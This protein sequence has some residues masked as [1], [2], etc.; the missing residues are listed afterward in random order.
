MRNMVC[1][2]LWGLL[3]LLLQ[4]PLYVSGQ[5]KKPTIMVVPS[6][7]WCNTNGFM[8]SFENQGK[9][10]KISDYKR[11]LQESADLIAA[12]SKINELMAERGFPLKNLES[13]LK[14]IE[15][16]EAESAVLTSG[17]SGAELQET[18]LDKLKKVAQADIWIQ[19]TWTVHQ[20]GPKRSVTI[21]LQGLDAY[22]DKQI[23]GSSGTSEPS[24][25]AEIPVLLEEGILAHLDNFN[26]QLQTHFDDL[27]ANGREIQLRIRVWNSFDGDLESIYADEELGILIED[28][29]Y[30]NT[31]EHRFSTSTATETTMVF[32]QV[33]MS[34]Y[35]ER[36]RAT[37]ARRWSRGLQQYLMEKFQ[38]QSKILTKGLGQ[39]TLIIG[40][41]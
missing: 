10:Q 1:R 4:G 2:V 24:F 25:T 15:Q 22:T 38:I 36:N 29:V 11:A 34:I 26:A 16:E 33:R 37:D 6:D 9:I 8:Q 28:W 13:A 32:E 35:D 14:S 20:V 23:A 18:P 7:V 19:L 39:A 21:N 12:I 41:K 40:E 3:L 17:T 5:A 30:D 27:F 31:V